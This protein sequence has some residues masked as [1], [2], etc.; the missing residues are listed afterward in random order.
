[1]STRLWIVDDY[2]GRCR[3]L[4][5]RVVIGAPARYVAQHALHSIYEVPRV[6]LVWRYVHTRSQFSGRTAQ[7]FQ[8][9]S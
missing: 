9:G 6:T 2:V 8:A 5:S 1:L 4:T 7:F 3:R